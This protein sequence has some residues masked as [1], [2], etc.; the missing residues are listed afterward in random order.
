MEG[1]VAATPAETM[2]ITSVIAAW[3][4]ASPKAMTRAIGPA[5]PAATTP[6]GDEDDRRGRR[7]AKLRRDWK[8][9][10]RCRS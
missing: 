4:W 2:D 8:S 9:F 5:I 10:G 1:T 7:L 3:V 6:V